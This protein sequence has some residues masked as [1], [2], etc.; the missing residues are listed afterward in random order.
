MS[1]VTHPEILKASERGCKV[2]FVFWWA[3][4]LGLL[5]LDQISKLLVFAWPQK[6]VSGFRILAL[7]QFQNFHFAFSLP[8]PK[9]LMYFIYIFGLAAAGGFFWHRRKQ[10]SSRQQIAWTLIF[11]GALANVGERLIYGY[12]RDFIY[13]FYGGILNF[14]DL[15]IILGIIIL[16]FGQS[17]GG[18]R[19]K[20]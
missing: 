5:A 15:Y 9:A 14:A 3:L 10:L 7:R 8:L 4:G 6:S 18:E 20:P 12:V 2:S 16:I 11:T 17:I 19:R 1:E 13:V